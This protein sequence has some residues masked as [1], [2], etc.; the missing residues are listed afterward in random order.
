M[1]EPRE[2]FTDKVPGGQSEA[3]LELAARGQYLPPT[4]VHTPWH[5][6]DVAPAKPYS[7]AGHGVQEEDP[8][9]FEKNPAGHSV[10]APLPGVL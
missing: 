4:G 6:A 5:V 2:P 10:Q 8:D 7:P 9:T 1:Q 3:A